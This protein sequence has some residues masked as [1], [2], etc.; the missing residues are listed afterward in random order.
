MNV[1]ISKKIGLRL[2][3]LREENNISQKYLANILK[4]APSNI[5][6]YESGNLEI[7]SDVLFKISEYFNVSIDYLYCKTDAKNQ[8]DLEVYE[9]YIT[10]SKE[11]YEKGLTPEDIKKAADIYFKVIEQYEKKMKEREE[12][13]KK[14]D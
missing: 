2:K 13:K 11:L 12:K 10:V 7:N 3:S 6:K 9:A 1:S 8:E 14:N 5:S 4:I